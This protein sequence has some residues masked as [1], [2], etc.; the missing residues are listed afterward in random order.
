M[1]TLRKTEDGFSIVELIIVIA[2][3]S[4]LATVTVSMSGILA[5]RKAH[6]ATEKLS[7]LVGRTKGSAI[8]WSKGGFHDVT[9]DVDVLLTIHREPDGV[10]GTL[11]V[12]E[13]EEDVLLSVDRVQFDAIYAQGR[14]QSL[15]AAKSVTLTNE[16]VFTLAF[17]KRTGAQLPEADGTYLKQV[18]LTEGEK[19]YRLKLTPATGMYDVEIATTAATSE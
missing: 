8:A 15:A 12:N 1:R 10:H 14:N 13:E 16:T 17:D 9:Q 19:T 5:G 4:V 11:R 3:M 18:V 6:A 7:T 2:F